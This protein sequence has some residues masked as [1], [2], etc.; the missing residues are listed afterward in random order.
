MSEEHDSR[1]ASGSTPNIVTTEL[2]HHVPFTL[3]GSLS[4]IAVMAAFVLAKVP[5][6]PSQV[7]FETLH[8]LH[9]LLSAIV[10]T[11]MYRRYR[12]SLAAAI[13]VGVA[14][15]VALG[16]L[17]DIVL[18]Y[19]GGKLLQIDMGEHMHLAFIEEWFLVWPAAAIG[20][21]IG[22]WRKK[23]RL[24]HSGHV[25]LSTWASLFYLTSFGTADWLP[26]LP[27]IF[28]LLFVAVW[29]PC[30]LGDIVFPLLI[31]GRHWTHEHQH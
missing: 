10:A 28:V 4:G 1:I 26:M 15:S 7:I 9:V 11:A 5:K 24:P 8:P 14:S 18:P 22:L 30:C 19:L 27:L 23:T 17:S 2:R 21:A 6:G 20:M 29:V 13:V 3:L 12:R 25:F 31:A 16:T